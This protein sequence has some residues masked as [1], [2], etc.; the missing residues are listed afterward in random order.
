MIK[1]SYKVTSAVDGNREEPCDITLYLTDKQVQELQHETPQEKVLKIEVTVPKNGSVYAPN[2]FISID[3]NP[4]GLIQEFNFH[5]STDELV[6]LIEF[7]MPD[8]HG[9]NFEL[10]SDLDN[11]IEA[12]KSITGATVTLK[13]IFKGQKIDSNVLDAKF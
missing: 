13:D 9:T 4:I 5:V 12:I 2:V 3:D 10:A 8:L 1:R 11:N 6:A 7:V